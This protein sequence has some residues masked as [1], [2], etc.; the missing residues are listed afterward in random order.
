M[1]R[2]R[3]GIGMEMGIHTVRI[4]MKKRMTIREYHASEMKIRF[5]RTD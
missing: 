2:I 5:R 1:I 4:K 3:I